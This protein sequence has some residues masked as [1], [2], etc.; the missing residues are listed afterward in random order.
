MSVV[1]SGEDIVSIIAIT[2]LCIVLIIATIKI[3]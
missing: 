3:L 2:G 1:L